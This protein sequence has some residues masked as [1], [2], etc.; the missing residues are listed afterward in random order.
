MKVLQLLRRVL[1]NPIGRIAA[2]LAA[3]GLF[4]MVMVWVGNPY[5]EPASPG[6]T[7]SSAWTAPSAP[8][9]GTTAAAPPP[10]FP[11]MTYPP[12][13][14]APE[15]G[16]QEVPTKFG[17]SYSVPDTEQW[18]TDNSTVAG[19]SDSRDSII[20]GAASSYRDTY[21]AEVRGAS[22]ALVG[23][24]GRNAVDLDTAARDEVAKAELIFGDESGR[25]PRVEIRGP[26]QFEVSG[27]P[28]VRYTAV[29]TDIPARTP[30]DPPSAHFDIVAT[31]GYASAEVALLM[32]ERHQ[33][34]DDTLRDAEAEAI[35][36]SLRKTD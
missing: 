1:L 13:M 28:A 12:P 20:Y 23:V 21:C 5:S 16:E 36:A 35:I 19:W 14:P 4:A 31:P 9:P 3:F 24:T 18:D 8:P 7:A 33:G 6:A 30:C 2:A 10:G 25:T 26:V 34:L 32:V 17:L 29:V 15:G 11:S 22:L 27:R